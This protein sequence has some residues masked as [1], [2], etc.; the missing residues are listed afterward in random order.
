MATVFYIVIQ[1]LR[2]MKFLPTSACGFPS[3]LEEIYI[4]GSR[5]AKRAWRNTVGE[6]Y[7]P[8]LEVAQSLPII[9]HGVELSYIV[10]TKDKESWE[11]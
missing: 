2:V 8:G 3:F 4:I 11:V 10:R 1:G 7:E 9:F 6:F 5:K